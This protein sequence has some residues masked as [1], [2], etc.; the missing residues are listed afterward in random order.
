MS[1]GEKGDFARR[2]SDSPDNGYFD[3]LPNEVISTILQY[4]ALEELASLTCVSSLFREICYSPLLPQH[5]HLNLQPYWFLLN[6]NTLQGFSKKC[7]RVQSI[8]LSWCGTHSDMLSSPSLMQLLSAETLTRL[9]LACCPLSDQCFIKIAK[10]C[11]NLKHLD[12]SSTLEYLS[13]KSLQMISFL[14]ELTW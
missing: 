13:V 1:L 12:V 4:L 10:Q 6:G 14:S 8:N 9:D 7:Q 3:L 5:Q 11:V 2:V